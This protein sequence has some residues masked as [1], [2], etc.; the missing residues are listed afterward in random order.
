MPGSLPHTSRTAV[1]QFL[2]LLVVSREQGNIILF[3]PY[4][5]N[6]AFLV[7][8]LVVLVVTNSW[9]KLSS[10]ERQAEMTK[11]DPGCKVRER[12]IYRDT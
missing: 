12:G 1:S 11:R 6:T 7:S 8:F 2:S 3:S 5:V 4:A 10:R 9:C